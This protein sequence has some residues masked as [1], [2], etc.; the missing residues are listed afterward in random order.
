MLTSWTCPGAKTPSRGL[1]VYPVM[2]LAVALVSSF[3][4]YKLSG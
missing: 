1:W 4:W 3:A 2:L